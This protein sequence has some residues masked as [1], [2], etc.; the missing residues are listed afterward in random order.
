MLIEMAVAVA[1]VAMAVTMT[2]L[3]A[4][5]AMTPEVQLQASP[6]R[7]C[8]PYHHAVALHVQPLHDP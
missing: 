6:C 8:E 7:I 5:A 2:G 1:A 3:T 4:R